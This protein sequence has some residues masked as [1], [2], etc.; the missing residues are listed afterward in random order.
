MQ[1]LGGVFYT[2]NKIFFSRKERTH[3]ERARQ[4]RI[5]AWIVYIIG[6]PPWLVILSYEKD[7]MVTFVEAGGLPSM[8]L[9]L[10]LAYR[11]EDEHPSVRSKNLEAGLDW[12]ARLSAVLGIGYSL[13]E[14]WGIT[15]LTQW[16]E[17]GVVVGFLVGTYRLAKD[18][19]DGYLWF[20]LMNASAGGLVYMQ[21]YHWLALQQAL[22]LGF[23]LDAYRMKSKKAK[24]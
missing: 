9:G 8:L 12:F 6:L 21:G 23:V 16:A 18:Q 3:G 10:V 24:K 17:L 15:V 11:H 1:L 20:L 22:S 2:L 13:Y 7:W 5:W 19:L 14:F 4:W